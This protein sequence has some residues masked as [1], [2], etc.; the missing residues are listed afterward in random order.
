MIAA[1]ELPCEL[2]LAGYRLRRATANDLVSL[3]ALIAED[4]IAGAR[5]DTDA[6]TAIGDYRA[7]LAEA[8]ADAS[9]EIVVGIDGR[10]ELAATMQLTRI[11]GLARRGATHRGFKYEVR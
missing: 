7:A 3:I 10:D 5:G 6:A 4:P 1:L 8:V 9:N 2:P 11:P